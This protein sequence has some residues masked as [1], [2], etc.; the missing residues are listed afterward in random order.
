MSG[1]VF[2]LGDGI[3]TD[4]IMP[5]RYNVTTDPDALRRAR[6]IV[7]SDGAVSAALDAARA[8]A[9]QA[10]EALSGAD[11]LDVAVCGSLRALVDG[12]ITRSS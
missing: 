12:L 9:K 3:S 11:R 2:L 8:E 6:E 10:D 4:A 1:R 7:T 5:G